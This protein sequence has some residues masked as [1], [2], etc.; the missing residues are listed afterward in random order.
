MGGEALSV[1]F[2]LPAAVLGLGRSQAEPRQGGFPFARYPPLSAPGKGPRSHASCP[3][4]QPQAWL[5]SGAGWRESFSLNQYN[6]PWGH[7]NKYARI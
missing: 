4:S 6:L 7:V 3:S 2:L 5:R 1:P